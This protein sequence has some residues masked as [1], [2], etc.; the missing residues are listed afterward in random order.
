M[1]TWMC[2]RVCKITCLLW[3]ECVSRAVIVVWS[4]R[5]SGATMCVAA[6]RKRY[7]SHGIESWYSDSCLCQWI[8]DNFENKNRKYNFCIWL[9]H[10]TTKVFEHTS[11]IYPCSWNL[12]CEP[13]HKPPYTVHMNDSCQYAKKKK[14]KTSHPY[15]MQCLQNCVWQ[16]NQ[17]WCTKLLLSVRFDSDENLSWIVAFIRHS[18][19]QWFAISKRF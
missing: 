9:M 3:N 7:P 1:S 18:A 15:N 6:V 13:Y 19:R 2:D 12:G 10:L 11:S 16:V 8:S 14:T 17:C 5:R 4:W